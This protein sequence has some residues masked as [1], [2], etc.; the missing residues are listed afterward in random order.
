LRHLQHGIDR[1]HVQRHIVKSNDHL[2]MY[3]LP[4]FLYRSRACRFSRQPDPKRKVERRSGYGARLA[5]E[6]ETLG[7]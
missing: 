4:D 2:L 5:C 3:L 7:G 1:E 6:G